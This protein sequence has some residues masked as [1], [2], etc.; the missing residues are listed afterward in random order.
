MADVVV[1]NVKVTGLTSFQKTALDVLASGGGLKDLRGLTDADVETIYAIG[2]NLYKQAKYEQA[3]PLFQ[4]ACLYAHN[5]P[6]YWLALGNCRQMAKN[7]KGAV[8]AYGFS[9]LLNSDDP[10]PVI[11]TA[12]CYLALQDKGN[13]ADALTLAEKTLDQ[14][15]PDATARERIAGLRKAL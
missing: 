11:Q 13:A 5:D 10:W 8:D 1:G 12:I 7:Y 3:E 6:R 4:F 14:G 9:Y 2:F 15:K